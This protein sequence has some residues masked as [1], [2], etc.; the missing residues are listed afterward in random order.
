MS[1]Y[2]EVPDFANPFP[3]LPLKG[4]GPDNGGHSSQVLIVPFQ[5]ALRP[6]AT[7]AA[8]I[9]DGGPDPRFPGSVR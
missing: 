6:G 2:G 9:V 1:Q 3:A 8:A 5:R 4:R 7:S